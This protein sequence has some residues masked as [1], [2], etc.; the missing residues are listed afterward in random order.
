MSLGDLTSGTLG[1][2]DCRFAASYGWS[3]DY[4]ILTVTI[5]A[6]LA[7]SGNPSL[8]GGPWTFTPTT[9]TARLLSAASAFHLCDSNTGGGVCLPS[10]P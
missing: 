1:A 6:R 2:C 3:A 10:T 5:G 9:D 4:Q 8:A 7:G